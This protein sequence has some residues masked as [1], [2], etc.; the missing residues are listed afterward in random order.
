VPL[1]AFF[2]VVSATPLLRWWDRERLGWRRGL[3]AACAYLNA[4]TV[5]LLP[6]S[7]FLYGTGP[8]AALATL[9]MAALGLAA[10]LRMGKGRWYQSRL[11]GVAKAM[12]LATVIAV[13][14]LLGSIVVAAAGLYAGT[15]A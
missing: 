14:G 15:V 12:F 1:L 10:F 9:V 13:V 8:L 6:I 2:Y 3:R 11:G 7:W 4:W 5:P